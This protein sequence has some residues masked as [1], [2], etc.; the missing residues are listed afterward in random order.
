[1]SGISSVLTGG[2]GRRILGL[3]FLAALL[4]VIF[5]AF[6]AFHEVGRSLEQDLH[7]DLRE[8]SKAYGISVLTGLEAAS[9]KA[10]E[11][12]RI[13]EEGGIDAIQDRRYLVEDFTSISVLS[14]KYPRKSV[15]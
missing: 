7:R 12:V 11:V 9:E 3:F 6:L 10:A 4:P 13:I 15:N 8:L 5:T 1:M 14:P 2:V